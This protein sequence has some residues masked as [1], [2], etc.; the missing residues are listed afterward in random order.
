MRPRKLVT[1]LRERIGYE[2]GTWFTDSKTRESE[3][4]K[5]AAE[6][7]LPGGSLWLD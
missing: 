2:E 4:L 6:S 1:Y 5:Q 3:R 7:A